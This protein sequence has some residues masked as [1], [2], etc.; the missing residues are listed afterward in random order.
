MP[1]YLFAWVCGQGGAKQ[2]NITLQK[3]AHFK[4]VLFI[5][6]WALPRDEESVSVSVQERE[7]ELSSSAGN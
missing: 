1:T 4:F 3:G 2:H 6:A 5:L 7:S